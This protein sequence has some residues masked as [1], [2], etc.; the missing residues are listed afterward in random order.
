[1]LDLFWSFFQ[2][3]FTQLNICGCKNNLIYSYRQSK[4]NILSL[5]L[6]Q[7]DLKHKT[8]L[9]RRLLNIEIWY[10]KIQDPRPPEAPE[11]TGSFKTYL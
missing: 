1:M 11:K 4:C 7:F 5:M 9:I 6:N 10:I 2:F 8:L 3:E